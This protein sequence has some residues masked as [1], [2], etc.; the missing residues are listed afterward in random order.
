[1]FLYEKI[2]RE[3]EVLEETVEIKNTCIII[4]KRV[5]NDADA[6]YNYM[7]KIK[8]ILIKNKIINNINIMTRLDLS[9][10]QKNGYYIAFDGYKGIEAYKIIELDKKYSLFLDLYNDRIILLKSNNGTICSS[11][12]LTTS[13]YNT[14]L[15][16]TTYHDIIKSRIINLN[17]NNKMFK[18]LKQIYFKEYENKEELKLKLNKIKELLIK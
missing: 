3:I 4:R 6:V 16:N 2:R 1:M 13:N 10:T 18:I 7:D 9:K 14:T 5:L 11:D 17:I 12:L 15:Y 8:N